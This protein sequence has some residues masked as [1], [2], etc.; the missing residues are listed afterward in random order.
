MSRLKYRNPTE[1]S[2]LETRLHMKDEPMSEPISGTAAG[3]FGW[4][5]IGGLAVGGIASGIATFIVMSMTKPETDKEWRMAL[6]TTLS[7][8]I[9]G[10]AAAIRYFNIQD[11]IN[12]FFGM[13]GLGGVL[14]TCG[15]PAWLLVRAAFLYMEKNKA[16]DIKELIQDA[17]E[18]L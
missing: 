10:G 8:S 6:A 11:W 1:F 13:V 5:L 4:K 7:G 14:L 15:L 9:F 2:F 3:I 18:I 16:K 12:D 17:K